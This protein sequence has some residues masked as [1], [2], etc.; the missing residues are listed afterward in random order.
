MILEKLVEYS[1]HRESPPRLYAEGP[2]RYWIDLDPQG[3]FLPPVMDTA[4]P[5]GPR[6][7]RGQRR[8]LPQVVRSS[9]I[10]PLLLADRADYT[11][12]LAT[13][14]KRAG[15]ARPCHQAYLELVERCARETGDPDV[16]A[17]F[18]TSEPVN[19]LLRTVIA[20]M[21]EGNSR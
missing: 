1:E 12:G 15:R 11:L 19:P 17:V 4:D 20:A 21:P 14:A 5:S 3:Q 6:T 13:G 10:R 8:L 9:E 7:R 2:V 18:D 16:A